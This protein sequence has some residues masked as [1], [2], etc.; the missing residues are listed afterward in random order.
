MQVINC[1]IVEDEPLAARLLADYIAQISQL[2]LVNI[3]EDVH[4]AGRIMNN[5]KIDLLL[6]DINL[7][8]TNGIDFIKSMT[9]KCHIILTTAYHEYAVDGFELDVADYL[10]KPITWERFEKAINKVMDYEK[11]LLSNAATVHPGHI[12][13]KNDGM[14]VK[15]LFDEILYVEAVQNYVLIHT[16]TKKFITYSALKNIEQ[17]LPAKRFVKVQRSFIV[18]I[19][20][21]T[22]LKGNDVHI[23]EVTITISRKLKEDIRTRVLV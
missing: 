6:L 19:D 23:G 20:K 14:M 10:L 15:I 16:K 3:C 4:S 22:S 17:L 18:A 12:F 5:E 1:L 13:I 9:H 2:K 7:P 21:I 8:R 11:L